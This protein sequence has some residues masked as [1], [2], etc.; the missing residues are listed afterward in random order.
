MPAI[1]N[2][3]GDQFTLKSEALVF[4]QLGPVCVPWY[5][6]QHRTMTAMDYYLHGVNLYKKKKSM[7]TSSTD[8]WQMDG[9]GKVIT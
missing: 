4:L 7:D 5:K 2:A 1:L 3:D 8:V 6:E 9:T